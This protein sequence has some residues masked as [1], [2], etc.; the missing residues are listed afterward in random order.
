M[1]GDMIKAFRKQR[2]MSQYDLAD[3][4]HMSQ[5]TITSWENGTRRPD[6]DMIITLADLF[7]CTTDELLER[8][9][10]EEVDINSVDYA[11]NGEL[12]DLTENEKKDI[13]DYIRFKKFQNR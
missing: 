3:A 9:T 7:H 1:I 8:D 12:R 4:V 13:L 11:L 5:S 2:K 6:Y 10:N